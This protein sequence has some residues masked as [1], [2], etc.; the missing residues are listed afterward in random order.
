MDIDTIRVYFRPR[1]K[2]TFSFMKTKILYYKKNVGF[3]V[4]DTTFQYT[5]R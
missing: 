1:R 3:A 5:T 4:L 2:G